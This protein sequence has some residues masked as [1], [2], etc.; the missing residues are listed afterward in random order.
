M[1]LQRAAVAALRE[2][3][4]RRPPFCVAAGRR[5]AHPAPVPRPPMQSSL[6]TYTDRPCES[7]TQLP[8]PP[9]AME[10]SSSRSSS[11]MAVALSMVCR[12]FLCQADHFS[13]LQR[14]RCGSFLF[15][16][17][18]R[19]A[20]LWMLVYDG[21]MHARARWQRLLAGFQAR[22]HFQVAV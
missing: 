22:Q 9:E 8:R 12:R 5:I 1:R 19:A 20:V 16:F 3:C 10:A 6:F 21:I 11:A 13:R 17:V 15:V 7:C 4:R 14:P 2:L 18:P